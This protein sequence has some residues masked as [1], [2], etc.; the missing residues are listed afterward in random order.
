MTTAAKTATLEPQ[1]VRQAIQSNL[2]NHL[3]QLPPRVQGH[4]GIRLY[5]MTGDEKYANAALVDLYAVTESQG[6]YACQLDKPGFIEQEAKDA[7]SVLGNGPR[8]KARKK[9]LQPFPDFI[10]Y[11][12]VLLRFS[13]RIDEFGLQGPCHDK[14]LK[15]LKQTDLEPGLTDKAMIEA[16]AAQLINYA[17]WAKQIGVGDYI[18]DYKKAFNEVYPASRDQQL[19]RAEFRNKIYGMTHFIFAASEY[20]QHNVDAKEFA[21]ILDY[22]EANIDRILKDATD[23]IIAEVGISFHLAGL[24]NHPVVSKTQQHIIKAFNKSEQ[25]IPSP[26]GNPDLALGEHRNVLAMMLLNWPAKLY[27]GPY[28]HKLKATKKYLPKQ[29]SVKP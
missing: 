16:W 9:A 11:T 20:Y 4:Y 19:K 22:F 26:K 13:S 3:Y 28:F 2:E 25:T 23:D 6:F 15:A 29:V 8:A 24:S 18:A 27:Q 14:L 1:Q 5:R 10:F 12:D 7:I 21:W 17:Y